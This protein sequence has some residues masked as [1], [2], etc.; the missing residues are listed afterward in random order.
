M[1]PY[2]ISGDGWRLFAV[3]VDNQN[4]QHKMAHGGN[5]FCLDDVGKYAP[6]QTAQDGQKKH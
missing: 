3:H 5:A 2:E 1:D 6:R 4:H